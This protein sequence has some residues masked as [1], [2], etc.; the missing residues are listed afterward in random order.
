MK[1]AGFEIK[2]HDERSQL[3][4][5][6]HIAHDEKVTDDNTDQKVSIQSD[7]GNT[8]YVCL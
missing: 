6:F 1:R 8:L 5:H 3:T 4:T 7:S 2:I